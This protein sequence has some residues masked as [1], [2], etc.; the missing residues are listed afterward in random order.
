MSGGIILHLR[1]SRT[2]QDG[3]GHKIG[4]PYGRTRR[5]PVVALDAWL[6]A[7]GITEG[8]IFRP[9]QVHA[10]SEVAATASSLA[11]TPRRR[12]FD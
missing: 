12:F 10:D 5:C 7:S 1:R 8:P 6:A 4:I 3:E 11:I 9:D 2:D